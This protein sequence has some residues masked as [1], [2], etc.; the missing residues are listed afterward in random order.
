VPVYRKQPRH[1]TGRGESENDRSGSIHPIDTVALIQ[2]LAIWT[3]DW[4][5]QS[6]LPEA[7]SDLDAITCVR[8]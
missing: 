2:A 4:I 7:S 5:N 8:D 1:R 3:L 6:S